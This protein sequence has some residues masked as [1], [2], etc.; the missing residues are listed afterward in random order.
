VEEV[1]TKVGIE[2]ETEAEVETMRWRNLVNDSVMNLETRTDPWIREELFQEC[3][4][5]KTRGKVEEET[6]MTMMMIKALE[7]DRELELQVSKD[8]AHK[9]SVKTE[10]DKVA[11]NKEMTQS[12]TK[13]VLKT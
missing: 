2:E 12:S 4:K 8:K 10:G 5:D 6:K 7:T 13:T 9:V 11:P 3:F 1:V